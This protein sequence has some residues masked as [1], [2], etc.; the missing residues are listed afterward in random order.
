MITIATFSSK[1]FTFQRI[2]PVF[3]VAFL[4]LSLHSN[5]EFQAASSAVF[6]PKHD[7]RHAQMAF[8]TYDFNQNQAIDKDEFTAFFMTT[9]TE[10]EKRFLKPSTVQKLFEYLDIVGDGKLDAEEFRKA[11]Q[12]WYTPIIATK[13]ALFLCVPHGVTNTSELE[14]KTSQLIE[15]SQAFFKIHYVFVSACHEENRPEPTGLLVEHV[16]KMLPKAYD[17]KLYNAHS[18]LTALKNKGNVLLFSS[19]L[20]HI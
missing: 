4:V 1:M 3:A 11:F 5:A 6:A 2:T 20:S 13:S 19:N 12:R 16:Q 8:T 18:H 10:D 15:Q 14:L 7:D 17:I 9:F